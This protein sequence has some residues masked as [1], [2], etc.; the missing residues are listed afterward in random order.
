LAEVA[1]VSRAT[2]DRAERGRGS[3]KVLTAVRAALEKAGAEFTN[4]GQPG[5]RLMKGRKMKLGDQVKFRLDGSLVHSFDIRADEIGEVVGTRPPLEGQQRV[6][7]KF[8]RAEVPGLLVG[9]IE[10]VRAAP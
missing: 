2:I 9:Y 3:E 1:L 7:V 6:D 8:P 4:G 10:L 5:V